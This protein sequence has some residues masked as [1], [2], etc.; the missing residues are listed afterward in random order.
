MAGRSV[1]R[2][3]ARTRVHLTQYMGTPGTHHTYA[4]RYGSVAARLVYRIAYR[5]RT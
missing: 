1:E 5:V 2:P 3:R 4:I